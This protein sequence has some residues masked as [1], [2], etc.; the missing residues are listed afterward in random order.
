ME[1]NY[2]NLFNYKISYSKNRKKTIGLKI[3]DGILVITS[4]K[5]IKTDFILSIIKK[6]ERWI[7]ERIKSKQRLNKEL[8]NNNKIKFIGSEIEIIIKENSLLKNGGYCELIN[9]NL[10]INISNNYDE[11][12][13]KTIIKNWYKDK[14]FELIS[15]RV[16]E[17]AKQYNLNYNKITIKEQKSVWGTCNIR[18]DLTFNWKIM[19]FDLDVIDYLVVHELA[20]TIYRNHSKSYWNYISKIIPNHKEL[21]EKLKY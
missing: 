11:N 17:Y 13:L 14:C 10:L 16:D 8:I 9:N 20:H 2:N 21:R 1:E 18:N 5:N 6:R 12:L 7:L 19:F 4:P 15:K 3:T